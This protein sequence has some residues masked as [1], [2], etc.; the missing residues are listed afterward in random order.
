MTITSKLLGL[1]ILIATSFGISNPSR[2]LHQFPNG[3]W[4]ENIAVRQNGNLLVTLVNVPELWEINPS[5]TGDGERARLVHRFEGAEMANGISEL[6]HD[7]FAVIA[8]NTIWNVTFSGASGS[9]VFVSRIANMFAGTGTLNGMATLD[10]QRGS[11]LI[12][13]SEWGLVWH[14]DTYTGVYRIALQH[15]TMTALP[16]RRSMI[17]INGIKIVDSTVYYNNCPGRLYCR[18]SIDTL[19]GA[20]DGQYEVVTT[21]A[22]ADDIAVTPDGVGYLAGLDDNVVRRVFA[23]G[24]QEVVWGNINSTEVVGPTAAAFGRN[25]DDADILYITTSGG[26]AAPVNG[27]YTEGG[28]V[29]A[30][31][32]V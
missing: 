13:D 14:L 3:T 24:T 21:G 18:V 16:G 25:I 5:A 26:E 15:W 1:S 23:N 20:A 32:I 8:S 31:R 4:V 11:V 30:L 17:G 22:L 7:Q 2:T 28:R 12:A 9:D 10:A 6:S 27:K 29:L 19:T